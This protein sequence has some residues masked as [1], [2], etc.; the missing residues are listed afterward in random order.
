MLTTEMKQRDNVL[1]LYN[2]VCSIICNIMVFLSNMFEG[3][4]IM[5]STVF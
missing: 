2:I 1:I 4:G 3:N 5:L